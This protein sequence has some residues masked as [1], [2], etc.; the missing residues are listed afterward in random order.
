M[1]YRCICIEFVQAAFDGEIQKKK[2]Q[3]NQKKNTVLTSYKMH[4]PSIVEKGVRLFLSKACKSIVPQALWKTKKQKKNN[5]NN[6]CS[7]EIKAP[8][9]TDRQ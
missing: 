6:S 8:L 9:F 3:K 1:P 2:Q 7:H 5:N 4:I